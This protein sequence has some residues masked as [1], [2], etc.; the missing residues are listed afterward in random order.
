MEVFRKEGRE[1]ERKKKKTLTI[2]L[3]EISFQLLE[4][5]A[6]IINIRDLFI[7]LLF[8]FPFI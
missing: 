8:S 5:N 3:M 1:E 2:F 7:Y 6:I 4:G